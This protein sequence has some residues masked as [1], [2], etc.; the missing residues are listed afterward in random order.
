MWLNFYFAFDRNKIT[1][2]KKTV[3]INVKISLATENIMYIL[4][5]PPPKKKLYIAIISNF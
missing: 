5:P 3:F 2:R 4:S 1:G